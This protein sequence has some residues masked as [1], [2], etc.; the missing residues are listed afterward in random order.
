MV[1]V[2]NSFALS[3][4][5]I[6]SKLIAQ[7]FST[8]GSSGIFLGVARG[9]CGRDDLFFALRLI[10]GGNLEIYRRDDIFFVLR[11]ILSGNLDIYE[12]DDLFLFFT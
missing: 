7:W 11:L 1:S 9:I 8:W 2:A 4:I 3:T 10:L 6:S 12:H 5:N